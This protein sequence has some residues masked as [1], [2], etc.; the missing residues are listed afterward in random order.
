MPRRLI[1]QAQRNFNN[2]YPSE[3]KSG[4][5]SCSHSL[6]AGTSIY[7]WRVGPGRWRQTW[8]ISLTV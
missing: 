5:N 7:L 2:G 6:I 1:L 8:H 4:K 3:I